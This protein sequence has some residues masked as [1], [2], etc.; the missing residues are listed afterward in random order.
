MEIPLSRHSCQ[1]LFNQDSPSLSEL[2][3]RWLRVRSGKH[4]SR[5][6]AESWKITFS[7]SNSLHNLRPGRGK[8]LCFSKWACL[9]LC[10]TNDWKSVWGKS[11]RLLQA[12]LQC[13]LD[14]P[15]WCWTA[16]WRSPLLEFWWWYF[17]LYVEDVEMKFP[18]WFLWCC[19]NISLHLQHYLTLHWWFTVGLGHNISNRGSTSHT[20][21]AG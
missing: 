21:W 5:C 17:Q 18:W 9:Y 19:Y 3:L 13:I 15:W 4:T 20:T 8:S 11:W 14:F 2:D 16:R 1:H 10:R 7:P 6:S 12:Y